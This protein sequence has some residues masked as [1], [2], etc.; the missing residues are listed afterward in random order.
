MNA[1]LDAVSKAK[2]AYVLA[3]TTLE[4]RLRERLREELANAQTQVDLAVRYAY[5]AGESKA[6]ILRALG[7][8]DY[9]TLNACLERT[10]LVEQ[11]VGDDPLDSVFS[12]NVASNDVTQI[13]DVTYSN[14]GPNRYSGYAQFNVRPLANGEF[15]LAAITQLWNDDY[16]VRNDVVV[17]LDG[18]T[19]GYY[20]EQ[21]KQWLNANTW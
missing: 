11:I 21:A 18:V 17:A 6:D 12:W 20:Y 8:K 19:S 1:N 15:L 2:S 16:T 9:H 4:A 3:K 14:E 7:T 5:N 10:E 13:L